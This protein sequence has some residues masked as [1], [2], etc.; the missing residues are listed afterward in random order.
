VRGEQ[1]LF[2]GLSFS[3]AHGEALLIQGSNGRGKTSLLR[4]LAGLA[5]P[6]EGEVR[7]QGTPLDAAREHYHRDMAYVGHLNGIKDTLTPLENVE[8]RARTAGRT[9]DEDAS[10]D[11]LIALGL[12]HH[13]D[14]PCRVLSCGQRRRVALAALFAS[15]AR[16]WI[17]DEPFSGLDAQGTA[18]LEDRIRAHLAHG[19]LAVMTTHQPLALGDVQLATLHLGQAPQETC[20]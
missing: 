16:L 1:A 7:W 20:A 11:V 14:L 9:F 18:L 4:L 15:N 13:L 3:L 2:S 17:L 10:V 19:G 8:W 5:R 12:G 6:A